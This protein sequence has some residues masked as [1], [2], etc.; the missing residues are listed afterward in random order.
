MEPP[1]NKFGYAV[2]VIQGHDLLSVKEPKSKLYHDLLLELKDEQ[3][4]SKLKTNNNDHK[5]AIASYIDYTKQITL[6]ELE[7]TE[8]SRKNKILDIKIYDAD[9][10]D[11]PFEPYYIKTIIIK[12]KEEPNNMAIFKINCVYDSL[13]EEGH[14]DF[15]LFDL[16]AGQ[17]DN[18]YEI[19]FKKL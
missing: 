5:L 13:Y 19:L 15:E 1:M 6:L 12:Y 16:I 10:R 8:L 17:C 11:K 7:L 18:G 3:Y 2:K 14:K 4:L 9:T